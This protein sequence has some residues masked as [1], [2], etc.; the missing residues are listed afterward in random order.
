VHRNWV[1]IA[2]QELDAEDRALLELSVVREVSDED[3]AG[4]LGV[5]AGRI[6]ERREDAL[7]RLAGLLGETDDGG[8]EWITDTMRQLPVSRWREDA[9]PEHRGLPE[10][11]VAEPR[12]APQEAAAVATPGDEEQPRAWNSVR[13]AFLGALVIA[14]LVALVVSLANNDDSES[15]SSGGS[16]GASTGTS[17][18]A[19]GHPATLGRVTS[20]PGSGTVDV[21]RS[22]RTATLKLSV[23]GLPSPPHGGYVVW[24]Y[25]SITDAHSL[26]GALRGTFT[27]ESPLPPDYRR[28]RFIDVSREPAD[29]NRNHSGLSVLRAPLPR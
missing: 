28:Y 7:H 17:Q 4:L 27:T 18:G 1:E 11:L 23:K 25:N 12:P 8:I 10:D 5:D 19:P 9:D 21:A 15:T 6:E 13:P 29:G 22:G 14:A 20:S 3:I 24:L 2:L 26:G 16:T